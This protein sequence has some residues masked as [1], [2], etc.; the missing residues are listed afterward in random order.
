MNNE[1]VVLC[2]LVATSLL[3]MWHLSQWGVV[4]VCDGPIIC[5][6]ISVMCT[7]KLDS[8]SVHLIYNTVS[9]SIVS[10]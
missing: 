10:S 7:E 9:I 8:Q 3:M 6:F 5:L 1:S 2:C 4:I